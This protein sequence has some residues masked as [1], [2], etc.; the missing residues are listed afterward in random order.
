MSYIRDGMQLT[1]R[2][3][4][5]NKLSGYT[6]PAPFGQLWGWGFNSYGNIGD[7]STTS[8]I[9]PVQIGSYASWIHVAGGTVGTVTS[10]IKNDGTLWTWGENLYGALGLGDQSTRSSPVQVGSLTNWVSS[11]CGTYHSAFIKDDGTLW[12][13]GQNLYG[14]LGHNN[15]TNRSSPVQV[16][17]LSNWLSVSCGQYFTMAIKKDG[18]LWGWGGNIYGGLGDNTTT[19]RS[20]PVQIGSLT[21]WE[22]VNAGY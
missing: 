6:P 9:S 8:R 10:A 3:N 5:E 17:S 15:T 22:I 16:G 20:S 12:T 2:K 1:A 13:T 19:N 14:E 11:S 4:S 18:T 7:N 21:T